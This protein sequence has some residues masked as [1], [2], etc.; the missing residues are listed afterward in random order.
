MIDPLA[1]SSWSAP[2]TVEGFKRSL[3]NAVLMCFAEQELRRST[4]ARALDIGCGAGRNAVPL[5]QMGWHVVGT[6]L[7]WPML[8]AATERPGEDRAGRLHLVL[9]PMESIPARDHSFDLVISRHVLWTLPHPEAAI[10]EWIRVL[11]LGGRLAV[12]DGAQHDDAAA[13]LPQR[14]NART[15]PEYAAIGDQL[16]FYGGRPHAEIAALLRAHGLANVA[17]DPLADLIDA[18][19]ARM[20]AEGGEPRRRQRYVVWGDVPR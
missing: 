11:R 13:A 10:D 20:V 16:P 4:G 18:Q 1:G 19:T 14:E 15:S 12:V 7:S 2:G 17:G 8:C 3:P 9:A 6:D 5:A